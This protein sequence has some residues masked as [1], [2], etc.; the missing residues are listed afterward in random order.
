ML[1]GDFTRLKTIYYYFSVSK[2]AVD[3]N[4]YYQI[5]LLLTGRFLQV[6]KGDK[7]TVGEVVQV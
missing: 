6:L 2:V 4:R 7:N 1:P 3:V 5:K